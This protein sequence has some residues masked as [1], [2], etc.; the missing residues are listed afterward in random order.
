L[1]VEGVYFDRQGAFPS[2]LVRG[3]S[4]RV[5]LSAQ[6]YPFP[7]PTGIVDYRLRIAP[8]RPVTSLLAGVN[9]RGALSL[10]ANLQRPAPRANLTMTLGA[11][12][13]HDEKFF[14]N[15]SD[16]YSAALVTHWRP[17]VSLD[18]F[19]YAGWIGV[20]GEEAAPVIFGA[21][22]MPPPQIRRRS[23]FGQDWAVNNNQARH[24]GIIGSWR[25]TP[26]L[27]LRGGLGY[28]RYEEQDRYAD[29]FTGV[30][31]D[32]LALRHQI[33][34]YPEQATRSTF[35]EL[36]ITRRLGAQGSPRQ[37]HLLTR[38]RDKRPKYGGSASVLFPGEAAI[39]A[40]VVLPEP[41]FTLRPT[42]RARIRQ[43]QLG[44]SYAD[45]FH[46]R[47]G[48]SLGVQSSSLK[49]RIHPPVGEGTSRATSAILYDGSLAYRLVGPVTL[50]AAATKGLEDAGAAPDAARNRNEALAPVDS[51]QTE[52]GFRY[53]VA[54]RLRLIS[55]RF[56]IEKPYFA[57]DAAGLY[58]I[59]GLE[60]HRG[61]ELSLSGS[62]GQ[63]TDIVLGVMRMSPRV[64]FNQAGPMGLGNRPVGPARAVLRASL[65]HRAGF[66]PRLSL[67]ANLT[68][69]GSRAATA[70]N[71]L[72]LPSLTTLDVGLRYKLRGGTRP[73]TLRASITNLTNAFGWRTSTSGAM[74]Y[75]EPFRALLSVT[76]DY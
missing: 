43:A 26:A 32:G 38:F 18:L 9:S 47:L 12:Y 28:S 74:T 13:T 36:V 41:D 73:A 69:A 56:S 1:R 76:A 5:G 48:V 57:I 63:K 19:S 61:T 65:N 46:E 54:P 50:F 17:S 45:V 55:G 27:S 31:K 42:T 71:R 24:L 34:A 33:V 51:K 29:L 59:V 14:G 68:Y 37:V 25:A 15:D 3:S 16:V 75:N 67:D 23:F 58:G 2:T 21:G 72:I 35:G 22:S 20:R 40:K 8:D 64:T 49:T 7:A 52:L 11:G 66:D 10:E 39:G 30:G 70:D 60:R 53:D 44:V 6:G 4:V 62:A